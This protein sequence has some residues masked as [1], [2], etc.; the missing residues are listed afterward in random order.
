MKISCTDGS[1]SANMK[2]TQNTGDNP[3]FFGM[4]PLFRVI[5]QPVVK[6]F[7]IIFMQIHS[8]LLRTVAECLCTGYSAISQQ[9]FAFRSRTAA[10]RCGTEPLCYGTAAFCNGKRHFAPVHWLFAGVPGML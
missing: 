5:N 7:G 6:L 3:E 1:I 9:N 10:F 8:G 4:C 2:D